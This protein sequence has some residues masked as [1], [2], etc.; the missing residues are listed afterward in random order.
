[1]L[2]Q[3]RRASHGHHGR[4]VLF[5]TVRI[6]GSA[7]VLFF[8]GTLILLGLFVMGNY[9]EFLDSSQRMLIYGVFFVGLLCVSTGVFYVVSLVIWMF[10]RG[11]LLLFRLIYGVAAT[12]VGGA[13]ALGIGLLQAV[14]QS[15]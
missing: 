13:S 15:S 10:R 1:M 11:H 3:M 9:Q 6:V 5:R 2:R 7:N 4:S 12:A 14:I 8:F